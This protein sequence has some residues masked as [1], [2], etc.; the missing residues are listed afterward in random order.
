MRIPVPLAWLGRATALALILTAGIVHADDV[1]ARIH[2][3]GATKLSRQPSF[4]NAA[5]LLDLPSS[6]D[7][8]RLVVRRFSEY[9]ATGL[10]GNNSS[11]ATLLP[12]LI[13]DALNSETAIVLGGAR[14][15]PLQFVIVLHTDDN[16]ARV[17]DENLAKACQDEG[18][19]LTVGHAR[20]LTLGKGPNALSILHDGE[21]TL[22]GRGAGLQATR[23][24]LLAKI[25]KQGRPAA[26][27]SENFLEADIDWPKLQQFLPI[28]FGALKLAKTQIS[29]KAGSDQ[30]FH[31]TA[32]VVYPENLNWN[33]QP[34]N[35][36][37]KLVSD[38]LISFTAA[39]DISPFLGQDP[40]SGF[41]QDPFPSQ[42]YCWSMAG[43][44]LENYMAWPVANASNELRH[45]SLHSSRHFWPQ[46]K[47]RTQRRLSSVFPQAQSR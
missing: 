33:P 15:Q 5:K 17:W 43:M 23:D 13:N 30:I 47:K 36:P 41:S 44:P 34:W 1:A 27:L 38:P 7:F 8:K 4:G 40:F 21:W 39:R 31:T 3:T 20:G 45:L 6:A 14:G 10:P 37:L 32:R 18:Q 26:A 24:D 35:I 9:L 16:H 11:A 28:S 12:P 22:I 46:N 19:P 42:Y 2:F 29:V 25:E